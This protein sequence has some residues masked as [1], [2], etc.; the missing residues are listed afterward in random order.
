MLLHRR[1]VLA[2]TPAAALLSSQAG[3]ASADDALASVRIITG[4]PSGGTSDTLCRQVAAGIS[5]TSYAKAATVDNKVGQ[6]GQL[7]VQTLKGAPNDGSVLLETPA[8]VLILYPHV[9]KQ[10]GYD[11]FTDLTAVTL[12]CTFDFGF[13][14][15]PAVPVSVKSVP[16]FL[17]WAKA[18]PD[19]ATFGSP[20]AGSVSHFIGVLLGRSA[21]VK[22]RHTAYKGSPPAMQDLLAGK[23]SA[24]SGPLGEFLVQAKAGKVRLLGVSGK[25]RSRFAP[26]V[27]TFVEQG[28]TDMVFTEWFGFFAPGSASVP[29]VL[30]ANAALRTALKRQDVIDGLAKVALE[31]TSSTAEELA[32]RLKADD[33]R[34]GPLVRKVGFTPDS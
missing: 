30:A 18:N 11:S 17:V 14:V 16:D 15:G 27:P 13:A 6:D 20:A 28:L 10:L 21:G 32:L 33:E 26:D 1:R 4:F 31:A 29:V 25:A 19:K 23:I 8:S 5:G 7:A 2:G 24:M 12:A 3:R 9:Y 34:W 22:L